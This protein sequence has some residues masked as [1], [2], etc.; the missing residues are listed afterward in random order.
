MLLFPPTAVLGSPLAGP[1]PGEGS[2]PH[3]LLRGLMWL[4]WG[5]VIS[6][7]LPKLF[8]K[9]DGHRFT[10]DLGKCF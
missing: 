10:K 4:L 9:E 7:N 2:F 3:S 1:V 6:D 5:W 8:Q